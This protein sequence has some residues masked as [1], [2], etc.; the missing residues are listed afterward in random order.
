MS[1][2]RNITS[3]ERPSLKSTTCNK[4]KVSFCQK[5]EKN[6]VKSMGNCSKITETAH[7][8]A[9]PGVRM[10]QKLVRRLHNP[11]WKLKLIAIE[12]SE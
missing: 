11:P 5:G 6:E 1:F 4:T 8:P 3:S 9:R 10:R 12:C 7:L 2:K